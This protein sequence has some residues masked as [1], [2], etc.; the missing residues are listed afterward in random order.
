ML[1]A[2]TE[3]VPFKWAISSKSIVFLSSC[4]YRDNSHMDTPVKPALNLKWINRFTQL[5]ETFFTR[6]NPTP[7][8]Q[9][10]WVSCNH[11]LAAELGLSPDWSESPGLMEALSGC[12]LLMGSEPLASVYSGHQFGHWAGQLGDGRAI[13]LGE[14]ST[15]H[16]EF[17]LQL[18]GAGVTP[19]SR[20]GDGRAVLRS[21]IRE[22]LCSEAM[23]ALGIPT[24]RALCITGSR[25]IVYREEP[26]R[27]AVVTRISPS[28]IRFGHFEHFAAKGDVD[29][30]RKL[31]DFVITHY[32][33]H[34]DSAE[35]ADRIKLCDSEFKEKI[36]Q[37][38]YALLL[39]RVTH[40]TAKLIA[41]WQ[42][43]GFCHGVMNTDNMS[44]LGLTLDYG[45]FQFM[46][47]YV[48][49][50]ICN[51]S[52]HSGRY[53]FDQQPNVAYWNLY[54]LGQA[55]IPLIN[56]TELTVQCLDSFKTAYPRFKLETIL[57]K[58]GISSLKDL[59]L[60]TPVDLQTPLEADRALD[61]QKGLED[62][63]LK[64][65]RELVNEIDQIMSSDNVD[66]TIF[67]RSFSEGLSQLSNDSK[68][69]VLGPLEDNIH[70]A[71]LKSVE[72]LFQNQ[73]TIQAWQDWFESYLNFLKST[74]Q[75][76][77][78]VAKTM[79]G[80]NP[81]YVLR[82]HL[83]EAA[84]RSAEK[85]D[86]SEI[87]ILLKILSSPFDEHPEYQTYA[88]LPPDWASSISISCSS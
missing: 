27:A 87:E 42:S 79:L 84:I 9:V 3:R 82:N 13:Y 4:E 59:S 71:R 83:G 52:D 60:N 31:A 70:L 11:A 5:G 66:F 15:E 2:R 32:S 10:H 67:W 65:A 51:H 85:G 7:L 74:D 33:S 64:T 48:P 41:H 61:G 17:E 1:W 53:A 62:Q 38:P 86:F 58:M 44:I 12:E 46:D 77:K 20:S 57:K 14:V 25:G 68:F 55:L 35:C 75:D 50:H 39:Y 43:V 88:D 76:L 18:K 16:G 69:E 21:S 40:Q 29:S 23:H 36:A 28:F 22:Y 24:T 78:R 47:A 37:N 54:C 73:K 63:A 45:P 49:N 6:L 26:E 72:A 19:Y 56:D 34:L 8:P 30:L 81:K 80:V